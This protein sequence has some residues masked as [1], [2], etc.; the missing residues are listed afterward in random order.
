MPSINNPDMFDLGRSQALERDLAQARAQAMHE[1]QMPPPPVGEPPPEGFEVIG[2]IGFQT[3]VLTDG[4]AVWPWPWLDPRSDRGVPPDEWAAVAP[5]MRPPNVA[6]ADPVASREGGNLDHARARRPKLYRAGE[7]PDGTLI[8]T[9]EGHTPVDET[10]VFCEA[11]PNEVMTVAEAEE[12][13]G[14]I[15]WL[16]EPE[17]FESGAS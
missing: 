3:T 11:R 1:R 5:F 14:E 4:V 15:V 10:R 13:F 6:A 16:L 2:A 7:A 9:F 12:R 17:P 8:L